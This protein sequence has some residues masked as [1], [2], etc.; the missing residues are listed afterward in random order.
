MTKTGIVYT[1]KYL[2]HNPGPSHPE[3]PKRLKVIMEALRS[4]RM[5]E[6]GNCRLFEPEPARVE[7]VELVHDPDYIRL[8]DRVCSS[9]GGLLDLGDTEVS[10][11]S[12]EVALYAVGGG[13]K[14]VD[15]VLAKRVKNAFAFVRP[16]GHHAGPYAASGFCI[17]NNIAITAMYLL[18]E[19][20]LDRILIL[21]VDAHHG[22]G[23]Q[24]VFYDT[25]QVLFISLHQD[26]TGF[27]G[28]GF[29]D[30]IGEKDGLGYKVNF[31]FPLRTCD[32]IYEKAFELI[33]TPIVEQYRPQFI[34]VSAGFDGH[35]SDTVAELS[36]TVGGY[37][38]TFL[39]IINCASALC[40]GRLAALL[41]GGYNLD[42]IGRMASGVV[43]GMAG[44]T[45]TFP[46]ESPKID[47]GAAKQAEK[48]I[49][50]VKR[51]HSAYWKLS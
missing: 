36:L 44:I 4:S 12:F 50:E 41:E 9:G 31:P 8:V 28:T 22:N 45:P 40:D 11:E 1:S 19:I 5:I 10:P 30:E 2:N 46:V 43:A 26:P 6:E 24:E 20:K 7:D 42:V 39:T 33:I 29:A 13:L 47:R 3:S 27:P 16:P 15:L 25:D 34:L 35:F 17:F 32:Q 18:R 21:D 23:T 38:R 51:V 48:V 49:E 14:A 37:I